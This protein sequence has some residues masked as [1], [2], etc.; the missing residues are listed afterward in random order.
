MCRLVR[1]FVAGNIESARQIHFELLP[2][3]DALFCET[4]PI[5][6]KAASAALGWCGDEIRLPLTQIS[7]ANLEHLKVVL[8]DLGIAQ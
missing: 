5:P 7:D 8:K 2:L 4:N 3:F 6:V 1:E